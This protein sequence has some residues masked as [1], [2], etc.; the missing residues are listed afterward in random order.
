MT[1]R[2]LR[3]DS[4]LN[5]LKNKITMSNLLF[6]NDSPNI[7]IQLNIYQDFFNFSFLKSSFLSEKMAD[8]RQTQQHNHESHKS[9]L[10]SKRAHANTMK[11]NLSYMCAKDC[12]LMFINTF[13]K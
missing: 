5:Q 10:F 2:I 6:K 11:L 13:R 7:F 3:V 12:F 9:F 4:L 8:R 1:S